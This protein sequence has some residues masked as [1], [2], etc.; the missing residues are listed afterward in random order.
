MII[1]GTT[2][3]IHFEFDDEEL[4]LLATSHV[5]VTLLNG[6][7]RVT[8]TGSDIDVYEK[9]VDVYLTQEQTL[10]MSRGVTECQI[11]WTYA[12]GARAASQIQKIIIGRNLENEVL[13]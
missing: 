4:D 1:R 10:A 5:Y 8:M 11:N 12:D 13:E 6:G 2:P 3:T 7:K 9:A